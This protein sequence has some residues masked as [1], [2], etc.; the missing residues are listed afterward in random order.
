MGLALVPSTPGGGVCV[1]AKR[2][3]MLTK[4]AGALSVAEAP[5]SVAVFLQESG[6]VCTVW[7]SCSTN[8]QFELAE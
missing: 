8:E 6:G 1:D 5:F 2:P 7:F 4:Q 3:R